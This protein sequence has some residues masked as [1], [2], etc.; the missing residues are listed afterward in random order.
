MQTQ[1][2]FAFWPTQEFDIAEEREVGDFEPKCFQGCFFCDETGSVKEGRLPLAVTKIYLA[3]R[4][5]A[6]LRCPWAAGKFAFDASTVDEID[7][8]SDNHIARPFVSYRASRP[9]CN[10]P[11]FRWLCVTPGWASPKSSPRLSAYKSSSTCGV[12]RPVFLGPKTRRRV[13]DLRSGNYRFL[14]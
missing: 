12:S 14:L 7:T 8:Q 11:I 13:S 2:S 3:G 1:N 10:E 6:V 9:N 5:D 4:E